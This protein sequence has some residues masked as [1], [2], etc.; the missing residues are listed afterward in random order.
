MPKPFVQR[1]SQTA[2]LGIAFLTTMLLAPACAPKSKGASD[3]TLARLAAN[4]SKV[5]RLEERLASLEEKTGRLDGVAEGVQLL[6]E[7]L[8]KLD[9]EAPQQKQRPS[10]TAIYSVPIDGDPFIGPEFAKV[11]IVKGYDFYCSYCDRVRPT[12]DDLRTL[13]GKDIKIVFKNLVIHDDYARLPALAACAAHRQ[14]KF[15]PMFEEIWVKGMRARVE[16]TEPNLLAIAKSLKLNKKRFLADMKGPCEDKIQ[17]DFEILSVFSTATPAFFING[18]HLAGAQPIARFRKIIDQEL[19]K[20]N[21]AIGAGFKL[22]DY[23]KSLVAS[24]R[25]SL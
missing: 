1:R 25:R 20:A 18:R 22:K 8:D 14:G 10:P 19:E 2:L 11:T 17:S 9:G 23:Y 16:L 24:G 7:K 4:E 21:R 13:Y 5:E 3:M 15:M 6:L 12:L